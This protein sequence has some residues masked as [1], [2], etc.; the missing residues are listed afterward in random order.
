MIGRVGLRIGGVGV[1]GCQRRLCHR[2]GRC[3]FRGVRRGRLEDGLGLGGVGKGQNDRSLARRDD[4][5]VDICKRDFGQTGEPQDR[6]LARPVDLERG[7]ALCVVEGRNGRG[8]SC[9]P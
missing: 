4:L 1:R 9:R 8:P 5:E 3:V 2:V 7:S 6:V